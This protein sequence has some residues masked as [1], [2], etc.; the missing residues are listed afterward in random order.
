MKNKQ[1]GLVHILNTFDP[2]KQVFKF[3]GKEF[4]STA[5]NLAVIFGLQRI[6]RGAEFT[7]TRHP[8]LDIAQIVFCRTY[9]KGQPPIQKKDIIDSLY[10]TA[11]DVTKP[12]DFL[13]LLVL[14][15]CFAIFFTNQCGNKLSKKYLNY[16]FAMDQV[17][18]P[19]LIHS[20]LMESLVE[21]KKPYKTLKGCSVYILFWFAEV[22]HFISKIEG[23]LGN[24]KPRF[25]RWNTKVLVE[26]IRNEGTTSPKQ[27]LTGSFID[28]LDESEQSLITP[29][30]IRQANSDRICEK[31]ARDR[32]RVGDSE[33]FLDRDAEVVH[34]SKKRKVSIEEPR[35]CEEG[36]GGCNYE[37]EH[38][39][40]SEPMMPAI[41]ILPTLESGAKE[42][43]N[44]VLYTS[45]KEP[46][47][48]TVDMSYSKFQTPASTLFAITTSVDVIPSLTG[49]T[50][51]LG[52]E[53]LEGFEFMDI[54]E[55]PDESDDDTPQ[56]SVKDSHGK[57]IHIGN[58]SSCSEEETTGI[59]PLEVVEFVKKPLDTTRDASSSNCLTPDPTLLTVS[60]SVDVIPYLTGCTSASAQERAEGF[61]LVGNFKIPEEYKTL[62]KKIYD[63][64]GHMATRKVIKFNDAM[65]LTCVTSLLKIISEME[66][67]RG[68]EL[69]VALLERWEG[70]INA[71]T[72]EFNIKWLRE[73]FSRLKNR[74]KSSSRVDMDTESHEQVLDAMQEKYAGL[75]TRKDELEAELSEV[76]IQMAKS[77]AKISSEQEAIQEKQT[78]KMK[79]QRE[80][81][82]GIMLNE[83]ELSLI[84]VL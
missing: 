33:S 28:P 55:I 6:K 30:E 41:P 17:S 44:D 63:K 36:K 76:N 8:Q 66:T 73:G 9:L 64:Y 15:F 4:K 61:E 57:H 10:A 71:E 74:W 21:A 14:Y 3:E 80:P 48:A 5:E 22:T 54:I 13:K 65:L 49:S 67:T 25:L 53:R 72:L 40:S 59:G 42:N 24:C 26:K 16:V 1:K 35:T 34:Q 18:W 56:I 46:V 32:D 69:R 77:E 82:I 47:D 45:V 19:D 7:T 12:D 11:E 51:A 27:D 37:S 2:I 78:Q 81:V 75:R 62:Y 68:A 79:F 70:I 60:T 58:S 50:S 83:A 39:P 38:P 31:M 29:I 43:A 84:C 52:Q 20:Y 23:E